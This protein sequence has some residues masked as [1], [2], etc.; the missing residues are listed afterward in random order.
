MTMA[1]PRKIGLDYFPH[2]VDV[3]TDPKIEP[4]IMRYGA[5]AYAFY[6]IHLEYCYR[7]ND[8]TVDVSAT[9]IGTEMREVIQRKLH[10]EEQQYEN[11]L[12]SF[13]RHGAF[14]ADF[15]GKTGKLTS[16]GIQ[17]RAGKVFEKR[18]REA[19]RYENKVSGTIS[20][21]ETGAETTQSKAKNSK[22]NKSI[23][24][25]STPKILPGDGGEELE[26]SIQE[27][28]FQE[29]WSAYPKK[30]GKQAALKSWQKIKPTKELHLKI[31]EAVSTAK[32]T[33]Q[34]QRENG[35]FIPNPTT[36][37][38]QGRWDDEATEIVTGSLY[39]GNFRNDYRIAAGQ[40][41][42]AG[43][44]A[45]GFKMAGEPDDEY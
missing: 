20:A 29:F 22:A 10:I 41:R 31:M 32:Q 21:A 33:E 16:Q 27:K 24:K 39:Q 37:L 34:W 19:E 42:T 28:R 1:R 30:T 4:A 15:Y 17:K 35:R 26:I 38:N 3:T 6:F 14:D 13:L 23:E 25:N 9:E 11:I 12:Q 45:P 8:L 40:T 5:A 44:V 18:E 2:D 36:W 7:S 43:N